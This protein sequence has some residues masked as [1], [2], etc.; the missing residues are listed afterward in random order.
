MK[1]PYRPAH[2]VGGTLPVKRFR[3]TLSQLFHPRGSGSS[4]S[5]VT[6]PTPV[7]TVSTR[8]SWSASSRYKTSCEWDQSCVDP[9][10]SLLVREAATKEEACNTPKKY[11]LKIG[12]PPDSNLTAK[13]NKSCVNSEHPSIFICDTTPGD[14]QSRKSHFRITKLLREIKKRE[15]KRKLKRG[16]KAKKSKS[17]KS[18]KA[19]KKRRGKGKA[20]KVGIKKGKTKRKGIKKVKAAKGLGKNS[21]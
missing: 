2:R 14:E 17:S 16:K 21:N 7:S 6:R 15:K 1:T 10:T 11:F 8:V 4:C 3:K 18:S 5:V 19:I 20:K 12:E 9:L 13:M